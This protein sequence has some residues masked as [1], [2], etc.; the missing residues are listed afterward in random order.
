MISGFLFLLL[1]EFMKG[2]RRSQP[3]F[4]TGHW[5]QEQRGCLVL[6][7]HFSGPLTLEIYLSVYGIEFSVLSHLLALE[8][9]CIL[10]ILTTPSLSLG[11]LSTLFPFHFLS[12][13]H[14]NKLFGFS[15]Y[16]LCILSSIRHHTQVCRLNKGLLRMSMFY[17]PESIAVL[18]FVIN[19]DEGRRENVGCCLTDLMTSSRS[20]EEPQCKTRCFVRVIQM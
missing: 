9:S 4:I 16:S 6:D 12:Q 20:S 5:G 3:L 13:L 7:Q 1:I 18:C 8:I 2:L 19:W 14:E 15:L 17:T 10:L 11:P